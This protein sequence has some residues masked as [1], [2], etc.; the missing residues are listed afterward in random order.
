MR[1]SAQTVIG[2]EHTVCQFLL[3]NRNGKDGVGKCSD[4]SGWSVDRRHWRNLTT[5]P[6]AIEIIR[7][8]LWRRPPGSGFDQYTPNARVVRLVQDLYAPDCLQTA[9]SAA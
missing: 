6:P 7:I 4:K 1:Q 5:R 8:R 9:D 2:A 3:R